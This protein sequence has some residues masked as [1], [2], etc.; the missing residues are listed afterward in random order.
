MSATM[1]IGAAGV[2]S[3]AVAQGT[4]V[5]QNEWTSYSLHTRED[6]GEWEDKLIKDGQ[7]YMNTAN[8]YK[9]YGENASLTLR[10]L[11]HLQ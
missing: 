2:T 7:S 8:A 4:N 10:Q 6:N 1:I 9:S 5:S 11:H 3:A